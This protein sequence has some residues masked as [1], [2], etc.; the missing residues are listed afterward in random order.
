MA[1]ILYKK[2]KQQKS[3]DNGV[4]W[5]DTGE[6][7]VGD[8]IENPSNCTSDNTKQCRWVEL[9]ES[10]GYYCD[11][12]N[13]YNMAVE[14]CS[15]NGLIWTRTG[16]VRKG[17]TLIAENTDGC[18]GWDDFNPYHF[19]C[20]LSRLKSST[21]TNEIKM[22]Y[23][24][25]EYPNDDRMFFDLVNNI[26]VYVQ[27]NGNLVFLNT[28]NGERKIEEGKWWIIPFSPEFYNGSGIDIDDC[29]E[30]SI[31][32]CVYV[33]VTINKITIYK[34]SDA[35]VELTS[36]SSTYIGNNYFDLVSIT[37]DY[38]YFKARTTVIRVNKS[39]FECIE[40][41]TE[42]VNGIN[43]IPRE[44]KKTINGNDY[45]LKYEEDNFQF[46]S[47]KLPPFND[48][49]YISYLNGVE[50]DFNFV[51]KVGDVLFGSIYRGGGASPYTSYI[52]NGKLFK[53]KET[54]SIYK[55]CLG[56]NTYF[57]LGYPTVPKYMDLNG[58]EITY[59]TNLFVKNTSRCYLY[60]EKH[61]ILVNA[62][63][64]SDVIK[65]NGESIR[66]NIY[67]WKLYGGFNHIFPN[68]VMEYFDKL[69]ENMDEIDSEMYLTTYN[70]IIKIVDDY[71]DAHPE[72]LN[73]SST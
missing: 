37:K 73:G 10:E 41:V 56:N 33:K 1:N 44:L 61:N 72:E 27:V 68:G 5:I 16:N 12:V 26:F 34:Y 13:K 62:E 65:E 24:D 35:L 36:I 17:E 4:T 19:Q 21:F 45:Y 6:F 3:L 67:P 57:S 63:Y 7:R 32:K 42:T 51:T 49:T 23:T 29:V 30:N 59:N 31:Y 55:E 22:D 25:G 2:Q 47:G 69:D 53:T 46:Y 18:G 11:G 15:E 60:S 50:I 38:L 40:V 71:L 20:Y 14:E 48:P 8:I 52:K 39:S 66:L 70:N 64:L 43:N 28:I 54:L 9:P 58:E